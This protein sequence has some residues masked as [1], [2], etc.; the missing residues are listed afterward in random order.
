MYQQ[1]SLPALYLLTGACQHNLRTV[2]TVAVLQF[3][4]GAGHLSH[5]EHLF[6]QVQAELQHGLTRHRTI[7]EM[8][9]NFEEEA[10][11]KIELLYI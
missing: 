5:D 4:G 11:T 7:D 3:T 9:S 10:L 6:A 1:M 2:H 8:V